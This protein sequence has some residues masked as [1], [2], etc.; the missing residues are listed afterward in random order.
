MKTDLPERGKD[1]PGRGKGICKARENWAGEEE[2]DEA[3][4]SETKSSNLG[5][6]GQERELGVEPFNNGK[7]LKNLNWGYNEL[8]NNL[9]HGEWIWLCSQP[10]EFYLCYLSVQLNSGKRK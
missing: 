5:H 10:S 1:I 7:L 4:D 3:E 8:A 9:V 6:G 2:K